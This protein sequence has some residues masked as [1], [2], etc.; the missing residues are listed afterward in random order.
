MHRSAQMDDAKKYRYRLGRCWD[1][2]KDAVLFVMLNPSTADATT[3]D[4]TIT[5]CIDFASR[6]GYGSLEVGNLFALRS[7]D[8]TKLTLNPDPIGPKND[9]ALRSMRGRHAMIV[10]A[11]GNAAAKFPKREREVLAMLGP[12]YCLGLTKRGYPLHPLYVS[13]NS[14]LLPFN[15]ARLQGGPSD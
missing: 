4:R 13:K 5:R 10:V 3:D 11:W 6:W 12:V 8:P 1:P 15:P 7:T 2:S 14:A 9:A